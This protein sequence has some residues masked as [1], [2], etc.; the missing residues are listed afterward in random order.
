MRRRRLPA[1]L[2]PEYEFSSSNTE[3]G[4]LR[5][6]QHGGCERPPRRAAERQGRTDPRRTRGGQAA[7]QNPRRASSARTTPARRPS[8]SAPAACPH[9]LPVTVQAGSVREPCGT[10]RLHNLP[11]VQDGSQIPAPTPA[12]AP[13]RASRRRPR[14]HRRSRCRPCRLRRRPPVPTPAPCAS[15]RRRRRSS[16]PWSPPLAV[17]A[18][19]PP[20]LPPGRQPAPRRA[21]PR[22]SPRR[23]RPR[24]RKRRRRRRPSR[25]ATRRVAYRVSEHEPAP[26]YLLG[27]VVLAAFAGAST[28]RRPRRGRREV[29]VA[30][31]TLSSARSQRRM[32]PGR[33]PSR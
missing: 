11:A 10:V 26:A 17:A 9:S 24:R 18:F 19:V 23:S 31:A 2:F 20:P 28:R 30:P 5:R 32:A 22:R 27:I 3:V 12:P 14:R 13:R 7:R 6:A 4:Q 16:C 21:A 15:L 1:G 33:R 29:R 25:S 8:R